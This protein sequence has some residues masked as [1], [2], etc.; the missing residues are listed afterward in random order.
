MTLFRNT[1][2]PKSCSPCVGGGHFGHRSIFNPDSTRWPFCP[3][4]R[5]PNDVHELVSIY[6]VIDVQEIHSPGQCHHR[7]R[8]DKDLFEVGFG[9]CHHHIL[10]QGRLPKL[11]PDLDGV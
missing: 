7:S 8:F 1:K 9:P 5:I 2:S 3:P 10:P 6:K 11:P 4:A